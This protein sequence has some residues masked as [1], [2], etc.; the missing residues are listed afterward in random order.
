MLSSQSK[1]GWL[2]QVKV[3]NCY[4]KLKRYSHDILVKKVTVDILLVKP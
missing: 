2:T 3:V 4:S 1:K